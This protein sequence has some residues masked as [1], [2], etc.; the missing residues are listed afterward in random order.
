[1][2]P[3]FKKHM[4]LLPGPYTLI[5]KM[6]KICAAKNVSYSQNL[7]IRIP[8]HP[9]TKIIQKSGRP[10]VTTSCNISGK[11]T[12]RAINGLPKPIEG[13]VDYIIDGGM[14]DNP[15][16]KILDLTGNRVKNVR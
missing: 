12:I 5:L 13:E 14:L 11:P 1:L 6:K 16:S 8:K 15:A 7:G 10:F 4:D 2:K 9:L 3:S